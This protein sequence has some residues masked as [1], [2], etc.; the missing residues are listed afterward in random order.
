MVQDH[1]GFALYVFLQRQNTFLL[2]VGICAFA[3][4]ALKIFHRYP[5]A[6]ALREQWMDGNTNA[7][8]VGLQLNK[9]H[10]AFFYE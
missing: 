2:I 7:Q 3:K 1:Y 8:N 10:Y 4:I 6:L 5:E 9:P